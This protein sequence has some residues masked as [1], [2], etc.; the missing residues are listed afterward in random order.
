MSF[1]QG[2]SGG[3]RV[4]LGGAGEEPRRRLRHAATRAVAGEGRLQGHLPVRGPVGW[5]AGPW[6]E[7]V[8]LT[9]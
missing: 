7:V 2:T 4:A 6:S 5:N 3:A 9:W 1:R 8:G